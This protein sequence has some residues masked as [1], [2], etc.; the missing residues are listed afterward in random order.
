MMKEVGN[1]EFMNSHVGRLV[2]EFTTYCQHKGEKLTYLD[3]SL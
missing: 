2:V 3:T 1:Y